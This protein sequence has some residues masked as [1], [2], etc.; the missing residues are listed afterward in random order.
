[1]FK[2]CSGVALNGIEKYVLKANLQTPVI[3]DRFLFILVGNSAM[4]ICSLGNSATGWSPM[5]SSILYQMKSFQNA[6]DGSNN[7]C[8]HLVA[9]AAICESKSRNLAQG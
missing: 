4:N 9:N 6:L 2:S 3:L 1:M 7:L 8:N 5:A